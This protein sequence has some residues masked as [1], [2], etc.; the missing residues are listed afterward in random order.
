LLPRCPRR[1]DLVTVAS[2]LAANAVQHTDSGRGGWFHVE[3]SWLR[4]CVRVTVADQGAP[5]GPPLAAAPAE[6]HGRGLQIVQALSARVGVTGGAGGR[7]VWAEIP[8]PSPS[9][10]GGYPSARDDRSLSDAADG[11]GRGG[12]PA[13][14]SLVWPGDRNRAAAPVDEHAAR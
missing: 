2:E 3:I 6:E 9:Q 14:A 7:T 1:D 10:A 8:W 5:A 4:D 13:T 11:S 12:S